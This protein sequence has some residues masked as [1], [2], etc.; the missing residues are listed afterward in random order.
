MYQVFLSYTHSDKPYASRLADKLTVS[1]FS[2]WWDEDGLF[3]GDVWNP[4]L[5]HAIKQSIALIVIVTNNAVQSHWVT[6][7]WAFASSISIPVIPL[8][9]E[10]VVFD[11]V[12]KKFDQ[13]NQHRCINLDTDCL[14]TLVTKLTKL[15][16]ILNSIRNATNRDLVEK[17]QQD[18]LEKAKLNE[19]LSPLL[20]DALDDPN[21]DVRETAAYVL[22]E[23][24]WREA[25]PKLIERLSDD[26]R[27]YVASRTAT[28][29][30]KIGDPAAIHGLII[31]LYDSYSSTRREAAE[32]LG[33]LKS[34]EAV[35]E[36]IAI[37][38]DPASE[39]RGAAAEALGKIGDSSAEEGLMQLLDDNAQIHGVYLVS[40]LASKALRKLG[41]PSALKA[42][43]EWMRNHPHTDI[44]P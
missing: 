44:L 23:M 26:D 15:P 21:R 35:P 10:N 12:Y 7:E 41:T 4:K 31:T 13:F 19:E 38:D 39:V 16:S 43:R 27:I 30:G 8:I 32:A 11:S 24:R 1:G 36:L 9:V 17:A 33:I 5:D 14:N 22:G 18:L 37:L 6:Y 25:V 40:Q 29:L 3:L 42:V 34:Q 20:M 2:A 28:A